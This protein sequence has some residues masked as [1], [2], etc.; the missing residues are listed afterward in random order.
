MERGL[1]WQDEVRLSAS[2]TNAVG[3]KIH[4]LSIITHWHNGQMMCCGS[5]VACLP[6]DLPIAD[7]IC[8]GEALQYLS[9]VPR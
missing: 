2:V 8:D 5:G 4:L 3:V 1:G 9:R 7:V 6:S